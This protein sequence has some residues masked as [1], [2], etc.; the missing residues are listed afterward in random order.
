MS[1]LPRGERRLALVH[2][3]VDPM[4]VRLYPT[5]PHLPNV[6]EQPLVCVAGGA[7]KEVAL[8]VHGAPIVGS[9]VGRGD[10]LTL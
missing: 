5:R 2:E 9:A 4:G 8:V 1:R 7:G 6:L 3:V 10:A